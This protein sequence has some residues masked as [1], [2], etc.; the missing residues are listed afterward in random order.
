MFCREHVAQLRDTVSS[1]RDR[2]ADLLVIGNG[3]PRQ[4]RAFYDERQ[5]DFPLFVDPK[6]RAY[7]AAGLHRGLGA[8]FNLRV[9][10]NAARSMKAG[11]RQGP[12]RGDPWQQ[13]A[14]FV[15]AADGRI[16][17]AH[18]SQEGGDHA[19]SDAILAALDR[20]DD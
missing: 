12:V 8:T 13:G 3:N 19:D 18:V 5:L 7:R 9:V 11:F 20:V 15:A 1:I 14:T 4:A 10:K 17:F 6:L 16:V 2:G